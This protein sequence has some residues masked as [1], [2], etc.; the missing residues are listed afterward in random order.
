V[1]VR[2]PICNRECDI[3]DDATHR[4]FCSSRCKTIDLGNWLGEAYRISSP[5]DA[6][7]IEDDERRGTN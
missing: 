6:A 2:C 4:P 1:R 7:D 5:L 3:P